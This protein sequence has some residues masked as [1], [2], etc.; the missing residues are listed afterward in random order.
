MLE[1]KGKEFIKE[2]ATLFDELN[3]AT[4][5]FHSNVIVN[6]IELLYRQHISDL[7]REAPT[8]FEKNTI[9][10]SRV[11]REDYWVSQGIAFKVKHRETY[12]GA[13]NEIKNKLETPEMIQYVIEDSCLESDLFDED[14]TFKF[15]KTSWE[16]YRLVYEFIND[17]GDIVEH[18]YAADFI[19][20]Q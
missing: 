17:D 7:K 19:F 5:N 4:D 13:Y 12:E 10:F 18:K 16:N 8:V 6:D 15:H 3:K 11:D 1:N 20:T 9:L 14:V 2:M